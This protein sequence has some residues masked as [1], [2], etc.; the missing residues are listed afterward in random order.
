M[1]GERGVTGTITVDVDD[2]EAMDA[3]GTLGSTLMHEMG[4]VLG[5]GTLWENGNW[6]ADTS[7]SVRER[8]I[9]GSK[10]QAATSEWR[11]LGGSGFVPL[12]SGGGAGTTEAHWE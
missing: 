6:A 12:E 5:I 9:R 3:D 7:W 8:P 1:P 10:G 2:V 11:A 4:H